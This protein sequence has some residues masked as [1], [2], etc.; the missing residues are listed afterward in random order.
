MYF[1]KKKR[2]LLIIT[3]KGK[4]LGVEDGWQGSGVLME[5]LP[6]WLSFEKLNE[7]ILWFEDAPSS[8][9][10]RGAKLIYLRKFKE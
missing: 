6:K 3:G 5:D 1:F 2:L 9:G 8:K 7:N 4:R 10:G